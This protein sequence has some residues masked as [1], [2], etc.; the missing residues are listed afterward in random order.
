MSDRYS[1]SPKSNNCIGICELYHPDLHGT[2]EGTDCEEDIYK[3]YLCMHLVE[4]P[5]S[6][7][8]DPMWWECPTR[9]RVNAQAH[10]YIRHY[11]S[12]S[13]GPRIEIVTTTTTDSGH[14][15]AVLKTLWLRIFQRKWKKHYRALIA[16]GNP[17]SLLQRSVY[18][19]WCTKI[20]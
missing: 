2:L 7:D 1:H 5:K 8:D 15:V 20:T 19:K 3:S 18:G 11:R 6:S 4:Y 12:V 17:R 14:C 9:T 16:R 13:E 10:P